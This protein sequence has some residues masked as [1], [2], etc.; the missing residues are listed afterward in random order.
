MATGE[1]GAYGAHAQRLAN[2]ANNQGNGCV[3]T[4]LQDMAGRNARVHQVKT[5][6]AME[7]FHVRVSE[8]VWTS[9]PSYSKPD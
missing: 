9:G 7:M 5:K 4:Q 3:I 6:S 8:D 2:R 1:S